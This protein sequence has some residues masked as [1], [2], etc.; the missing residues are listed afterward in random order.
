MVLYYSCP[1]TV[2]WSFMNRNETEGKIGGEKKSQSRSIDLWHNSTQHVKTFLMSQN[3]DFTN[4][5]CNMRHKHVNFSMV[6]I[7]NV[8]L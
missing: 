6:R 3:S 2:P 7:K 5:G 4:S 8:P 1:Y